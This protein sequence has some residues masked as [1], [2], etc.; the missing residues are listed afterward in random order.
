LPHRDPLRFCELAVKNG[1][2]IFRVFDSLNYLPNMILGMDAVRKAG[3]VVE[4]AISYTGDVS[5]PAKTKYDLNY[6]LKLTDD[7][8]KAG[9]HILG[10]KVGLLSGDCCNNRFV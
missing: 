1:M 5:N 9:T 2:D 3:G 4:A 6:Y 8:V 10:I 7:L